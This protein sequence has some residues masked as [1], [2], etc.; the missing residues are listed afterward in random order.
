MIVLD[1]DVLSE[2]ARP[3]PSQSVIDWVDEQD[4]S[5][6]MTTA[7][8]AAEIRAGVA[9]LPAGRRK[10]EIGRRMEVLLGVTFGGHVQAFDLDSSA[11]YAD[12]VAERTKAG[13]P[14]T[15]VDA[16]IA[17]I[18]VRHGSALATRNT[19]DFAGIGLELID[20]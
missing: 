4:S 14:I 1:T 18:C 5:D 12:I 20:P 10:R 11:C 6:L 13:R 17:A 7:L 16:Q 9:L 3:S 15:A 2:L 19:P 8:T